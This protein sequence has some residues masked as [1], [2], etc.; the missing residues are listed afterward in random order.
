LRNG[1]VLNAEGVQGLDVFNRRRRQIRDNQPVHATPHVPNVAAW[2]VAG[3]S[4]V[5]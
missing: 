4:A 1:P 5:S 2:F 3:G